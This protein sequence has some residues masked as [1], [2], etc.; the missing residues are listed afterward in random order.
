MA[1]TGGRRYQQ[2]LIRHL[3]LITHITF[4]YLVQE[5]T[6]TEPPVLIKFRMAWGKRRNEDGQ[7]SLSSEPS[8]ILL[9]GAS[10]SNL[11]P[12]SNSVATSTRSSS[13][14]AE[15]NERTQNE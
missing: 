2:S 9:P 14:S 1:E 10:P 8:S 5:L 13:A 3:Q 4:L 7:Q 6:S 11:T 12:R 15:D